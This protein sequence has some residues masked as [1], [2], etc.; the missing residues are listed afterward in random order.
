[1]NNKTNKPLPTT[2]DPKNVLPTENV[3]IYKNDKGAGRIFQRNQNGY[4]RYFP[5]YATSE[6]PNA[7]I[8]DAVTGIRMEGK[9][10]NRKDEQQYIKVKV[11]TG[12]SLQNANGSKTLFFETNNDFLHL[13]RVRDPENKYE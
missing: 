2:K 6:Y 1:M 13:I 11:A 7:P 3:V 5:V 4:G 9:V 10:G 8:R 12:Q